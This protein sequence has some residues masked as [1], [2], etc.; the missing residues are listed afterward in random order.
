MKKIISLFLILISLNTVAF[1]KMKVLNKEKIVYRNSF[2]VLTTACVNN[3]TVLITEAFRSTT[4]GY[5]LVSSQSVLVYK[6]TL[7]G[8]K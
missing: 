3:M 5:E 2:T 1:A 4:N 7:N 6:N 8:C